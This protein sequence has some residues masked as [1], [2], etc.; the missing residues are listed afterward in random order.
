MK[1][2]SLPLPL[3]SEPRTPYTPEIPV[4]VV[5]Q[6]FPH[7]EIR[8]TLLAVEPFRRHLADSTAHRISLHAD[9]KPQLEAPVALNLNFFKQGLPVQLEAVRHVMG[10]YP[11]QQMK[12]Q[13]RR[14]AEK[15]FQERPPVL[16]SAPHVSRAAD[17]IISLLHKG[18]HRDNHVEPVGRVRH[19]HE[20]HLGC[21]GLH[22][23][24]DG[25]QRTTSKRVQHERDFKP[26]VTCMFFDDGHSRI[27]VKVVYDEYPFF[28]LYLALNLGKQVEP[29]PSCIY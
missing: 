19:H 17:H 18:A 2:T 1:K 6:P 7:V 13:P 3:P 9:F 12:R 20:D 16:P 21:G 22:S 10:R 15:P 8:F 27:A 29:S 24:L 23:R 5:R 28:R 25:I 11:R 14:A 26:I 4:Q